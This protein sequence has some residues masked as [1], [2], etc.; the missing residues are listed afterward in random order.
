MRA[1]TSDDRHT[2]TRR[3]RDERAR[4]VSEAARDEARA[5][6]GRETTRGMRAGVA[7]GA[8]C[9]RG[10]DANGNDAVGC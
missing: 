6:E 7:R 1:P 10:R 5:R 8:R 9:A 4:D 2:S 3:T